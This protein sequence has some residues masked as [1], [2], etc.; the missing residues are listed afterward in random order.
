MRKKNQNQKV[1]DR[2]GEMVS[3]AR[4]IDP[5]ELNG[6]ELFITDCI[7]KYL[8]HINEDDM[9]RLEKL[10]AAIE[11]ECEAALSGKTSADAYFHLQ[12]LFGD[13]IKEVISST[14][15]IKLLTGMRKEAKQVKE[16]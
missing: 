4:R 10:R 15:A 13:V 11:E 1:I 6:Q 8:P 14:D 5:S 3:N 12:Q 7:R 16:H 2:L 9:K